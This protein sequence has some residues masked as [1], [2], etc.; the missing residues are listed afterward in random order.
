MLF[1]SVNKWKVLEFDSASPAGRPSQTNTTLTYAAPE[2]VLAEQE[3]K[4]QIVPR[5]SGDLWSLGVIA[6]ELL[7]GQLCPE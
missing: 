4:T 2:I 3:R 5:A 7:T 6:F 1:R